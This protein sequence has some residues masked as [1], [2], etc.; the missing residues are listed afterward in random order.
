MR[1]P[2]SDFDG[3]RRLVNFSALINSSLDILTVLNQ[4]MDYV[5]Y[6]LDAEASS[7]FEV[8][9]DQGDLFFRLARGE[10]AHAITGMRLKMGEGVAGTVALTEEPLLITDTSKDPRFCQRFDGH[11]GFCTRSILCVPLKSRERLVGV[12]EVL[13]KKDPRGFDE[14]DREILILV[15]NLIGTALENARL[16]GRLQDRLS[17]TKE[18]LKVA[19]EKLLR[20]ER[21][22]ALGML[23]KGVAHEVRNP[24]AI[25]GG[26]VHRLE[27]HLA[28][29]DPNRATLEIINS[30]IRKLE[31]MVQEIETFT[32]LGEPVLR[33]TKLPELI[34]RV[35]TIHADQILEAHVEVHTAFPSVLPPVPADPE[36]L[37]LALGNLVTNALEAMPNGGGLEI[38]LAAEP[39]RVLIT[40]KDAGVGISSEDLSRVFDPFFST[41]PQGTGMGLTA[42]YHIVANHLGEIQIQS[43]LGQGTTVHLW[44]PR[45]SK[46]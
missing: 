30:Q 19:Q 44:I 32:K 6:L 33:L 37:S 7:I 25:I 15:G 8:D 22:A 4:A 36:L 39:D 46:E 26:F 34:N 3:L 38:S 40:L 28:T 42:V 2:L 9:P 27:K 23:S 35:L 12:L 14:T 41:K 45:W 17:A 13:N 1:S 21:L 29:N 16:Y 18:E 20:S 24:I 5:E 43:K 10:K 31:Q 11:S